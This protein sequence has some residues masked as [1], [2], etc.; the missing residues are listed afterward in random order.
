[1]HKASHFQLTLY[2]VNLAVDGFYS[3]LE[4]LDKFY[5]E[6]RSGTKPVDHSTSS[7]EAVITVE[8]V[9]TVNLFVNFC[10]TWK[11]RN[12]DVI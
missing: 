11:L 1:M 8:Q 9:L 7:N 10:E 12:L 4:M 2:V 3:I 5:S 6:R